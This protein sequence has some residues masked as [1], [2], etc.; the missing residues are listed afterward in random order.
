MILENTRLAI[1]DLAS[2]KL[3]TFLSVLGIV[4]GVGSVVAIPGSRQQPC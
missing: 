2:N 3:R 1:K 4:I